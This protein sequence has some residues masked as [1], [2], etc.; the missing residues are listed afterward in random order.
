[1]SADYSILGDW[2][3]SRMRLFRVVSGALLDRIDGPGIG[4][5][6]VAPVQALLAAIAPWRAE[7]DPTHVLLCGMAGARNGLAEAPY[8]EC[9]IDAAA[10]SLQARMLQLDGI[11]VAVAAG[12]ACTRADASPDVLRG[13]ET[14]LFG[15]LRIDPALARGQRLV[16]LPGTHCKW[17]KLDNGR[18]IDFQTFPSGEL[19]ALLR[20]QSSLTR[21]GS[22]DSGETEGFDAGLAS[23]RRRD[24]LLGQLFH[25]RSAQLRSGRTRGWA[26]GYL[27]GL[28]IGSEV[29]DV[30][31]GTNAAHPIAL[32][33]DPQLTA[34]YRRALDAQPNT[35]DTY[36][37]DACALAGLQLFEE[38]LSWT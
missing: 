30:L 14:Q 32:I 18:V 3:S 5:L 28:I 34:R 4:A 13:E 19:F 17:L 22:D 31:A 24:G 7:G 20:D 16:A 6:S 35:I 11:P 33:G 12:L 15:A 21:V 9:P 2:G 8:A 26:L 36:D 37:G 23:A 1:M 27:S 38:S 10:W 29:E 25:A